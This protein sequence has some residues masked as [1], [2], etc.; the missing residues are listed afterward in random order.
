MGLTQV[1]TFEANLRLAQR[2]HFVVYMYT[3]IPRDEW[4]LHVQLT[5]LHS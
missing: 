2:A 4:D 1:D 5:Y 3:N